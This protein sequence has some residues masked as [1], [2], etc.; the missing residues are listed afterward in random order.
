MRN[1]LPTL[2]RWGAVGRAFGAAAGGISMV[3]NE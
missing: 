3:D 1:A 2:T